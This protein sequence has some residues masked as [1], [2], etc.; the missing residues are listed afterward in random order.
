MNETFAYGHFQTYG[1]VRLLIQ[2]TRGMPITPFGQSWL[3]KRVIFL[4]RRI[5]VLVLAGKP[6]DISTFGAHF[7]LYP[8][9]NVCEKRI[10]F[11]PT[12]FDQFERGFLAKLIKPDFTFLDIGANIG[13]YS[14][15][16]AAMAHAQGCNVRIIALE[17]QPEIFD[18][19]IY[20][21]SINPFANIKALAIAMADREGE[22]TLFL[23]QRNKGEA[24]VKIVSPDRARQVRV[25]S[26]SLLALIRDEGFTQV[27]AI[28]LDVE[29][30]EDIILQQFFV[31]AP[32]NLWPKHLIMDE[33]E[34]RWGID[35][36]ALLHEKG[37]KTKVQ[38]RNNYILELSE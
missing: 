36:L 7:R 28:K 31:D 4:I 11:S 26:R 10:L 37:Y 13:G 33:G 34:G 14:L 38:T 29:G 35:L 23:D 5:A 3:G 27:D 6:V 15:A 32:K 20:N 16:V 8:Y 24:S 22:V 2:F 17:P 30:A 19:L 21:I 12:E 1:L 9:N 25:T 18:R